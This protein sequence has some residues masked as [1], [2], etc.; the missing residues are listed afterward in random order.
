MI[1]VSLNYRLDLL[2]FLCSQDISAY[3]ASFNIPEP[4]GNYALRDQRVAFSW[5]HSHLLGF[6]GDPQNI[7]VFGESA[8][9][10]SISY[11][12]CS[13]LLSINTPAGVKKIPPFRRA[14]L[15][16]SPSA[17]CVSFS[18]YEL[19]YQRVLSSLSISPSDPHRVEKLLAVPTDD[20]VAASEEVGIPH[21]FVLA[22]ETLFPI[23]PNTADQGAIINGCDW[24]DELII[25]D[26]F[27]EVCLP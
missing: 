27:Y 19:A 18:D 8:G 4:P 13:T 15:Q 16:S 12:L 21:M 24:I 3:V 11:H 10:W 9:A 2:G 26:T 25:G 6:G 1:M 5:L 14:I 17:Q 20:I 22:D 7:T 23:L